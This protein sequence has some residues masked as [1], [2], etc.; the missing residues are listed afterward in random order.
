MHICCANEGYAFLYKLI[1]PWAVFA[2]VSIFDQQHAI[3]LKIRNCCERCFAHC[4]APSINNPT[5]RWF[6]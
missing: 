2:V 5:N 1:R 6:I 4:A 3:A